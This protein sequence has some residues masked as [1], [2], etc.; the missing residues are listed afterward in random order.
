MGIPTELELIDYGEVCPTGGEKPE[1]HRLRAPYLTFGF[2]RFFFFLLPTDACLLML[3]AQRGN[4]MQQ[5]QDLHLDVCVTVDI[6]I[7]SK[8]SK[9]YR[10]YVKNKSCLEREKEKENRKFPKTYAELLIVLLMPSFEYVLPAS[11]FGFVTRTSCRN[12]F[13]SLLYTGWPNSI[14]GIGSCGFWLGQP[15]HAFSATL[16]NECSGY[17]RSARTGNI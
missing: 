6:S 10:E 2:L 15:I 8:A 7:F 9:H 16:T 11:V 17:V 5:F 3:K 12:S 13:R 4:Y 1:K 14:K